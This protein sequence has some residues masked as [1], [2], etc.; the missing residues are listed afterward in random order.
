MSIRADTVFNAIGWLAV[1]A[2][3]GGGAAFARHGWA[4]DTALYGALAGLALGSL[5]VVAI[6]WLVSVLWR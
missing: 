4:W 3:A 6:A 5:A 2:M 1:A